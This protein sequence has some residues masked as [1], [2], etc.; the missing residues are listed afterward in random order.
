LWEPGTST[1]RFLYLHSEPDSVAWG[2]H[3]LYLSRLSKQTTGVANCQC[4]EAQIQRNPIGCALWVKL[5]EFANACR[6][7]VYAIKQRIMSHWLTWDLK[8]PLFAMSLA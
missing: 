3:N 4:R 1:Y 2:S 7:S 8:Y 6:T 5:K